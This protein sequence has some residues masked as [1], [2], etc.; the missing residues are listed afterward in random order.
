MPAERFLHPRLARD[1]RVAR[2]TDLEARVFVEGYLLAA[3]DFGVMRCSALPVQELNDALATRPARVIEQCLARLVAAGLLLTFEYQ[4]RRYVCSADWQ[5][6]QRVRWPRA[7]LN[8]APPPETLARCSAA[9]Q[10]LFQS[11]DDKRPTASPEDYTS[12]SEALRENFRSASEVLPKDSQSASEVLPS[13]PRAGAREEANGYQLEAKGSRLKARRANGENSR[14]TYDERFLAFWAAYPKKVGKGE[15][16][17]AWQKLRP[18]DALLTLMLAAV[19]WQRTQDEWLR[20][21]GRYVPHPKTW[22]NARRWEDAPSDAP[23]LSDRTIAMA[24]AGEEFMNDR[25]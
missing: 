20:S 15:A 22:L 1:A 19:G 14:A 3:D 25:R 7:T 4:S 21:G 5:D 13:L 24:R 18:D 6:D 10:E 8:P 9:T 16:W 2:L 17:A 12:T 23:H 11:S